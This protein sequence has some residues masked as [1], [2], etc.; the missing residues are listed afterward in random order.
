M[1]RH[2]KEILRIKESIYDY[3]V[4]RARGEITQ[5]G[6]IYLVYIKTSGTPS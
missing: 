1:K 4:V 3:R 2:P 6:M 5:T